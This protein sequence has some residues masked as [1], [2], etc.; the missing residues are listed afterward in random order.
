MSKILLVVF[1]VVAVAIWFTQFQ[2]GIYR[3]FM[4][5]AKKTTATIM[6]KGERVANPKTKRMDR[7]VSFSFTDD[8]GVMHTAESDIEY[9]DLWQSFEKGQVQ[10]AYYN[11]ANP[12]ENHLA[13][14][15]GRRIK[16]ADAIQNTNP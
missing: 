16:L 2:G 13:V 1:L 15:L 8:R 11:P 14:V 4:Q 6:S 7:W 9:D 3:Q 10:D 5:T 12:S